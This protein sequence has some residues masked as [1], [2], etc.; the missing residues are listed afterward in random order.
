MQPTTAPIRVLVAE[1]NEDDIVLIEEAFKDCPEV[2]LV[3]IVEDGEQVL[4]FLHRTGRYRQAPVPH[5]VLLDINMPKKSGIDVLREIKRE[6]QYRTLPVAM[7]TTSDASRDVRECYAEGACSY[8]VKPSDLEE[9]RHV[10]SNFEQY[11]TNVSRL[12]DRDR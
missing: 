8:I 2:H 11:W 9:F 10:V 6:R 1:D 3:G 5:L 4:A 7:L 12:P